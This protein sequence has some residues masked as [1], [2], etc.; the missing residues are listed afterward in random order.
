MIMLMM[1]IG[2]SQITST[3]AFEHYLAYGR[4]PDCRLFEEGQRL[5][6]WGS[7]DRTTFG[8]VVVVVDRADRA[9]EMDL[10]MPCEPNWRKSKWPSDRKK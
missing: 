5:G 9:G 4:V 10:L 8:T 2:C 1:M 6:E 7:V 3:R